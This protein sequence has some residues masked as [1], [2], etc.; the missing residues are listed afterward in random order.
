MPTEAMERLLLESFVR[1]NYEEG[2]EREKGRYLVNE[3]INVNGNGQ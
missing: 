1:I 2:L 3:Q